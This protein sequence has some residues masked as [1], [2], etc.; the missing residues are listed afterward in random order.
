MSL[1]LVRISKKII[2]RRKTLGGLS[3]IIV[4]VAI[5]VQV[6]LWS[7]TIALVATKTDRLRKT[8]VNNS[9]NDS[10]HVFP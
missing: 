5:I 3:L 6:S 9:H 7:A 2:E 4:V 1:Y 10:T 8:T